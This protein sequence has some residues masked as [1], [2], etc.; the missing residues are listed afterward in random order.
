MS[1]EQDLEWDSGA[2]AAAADALVQK[3]PCFASG[4]PHKMCGGGQCHGHD[5]SGPA[6]ESGIVRGEE[7]EWSV[8]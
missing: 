4:I 2:A 1:T 5:W 6:K 3:T 8:V 7:L